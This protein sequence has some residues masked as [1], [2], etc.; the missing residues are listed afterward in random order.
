MTCYIAAMSY[1]TLEVEI[2]HGQVVAKGTEKLPDKAA[3]LLTILPPAPEAPAKMTPLE[4]LEAL[5]KHLQLTP[6]KAEA[7]KATI[8]DARR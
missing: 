5:Q 8:R 2:D 7:W 6:E 1:V 3:G 4:A